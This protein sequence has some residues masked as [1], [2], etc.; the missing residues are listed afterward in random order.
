VQGRS[1]TE[2]DDA[3]LGVLDG[4]DTAH[5][6]GP[7][8]GVGGPARPGGGTAPPEAGSARWWAQ[9]AAAESRRRPRPGGLSCE[10]II[11]AAL[12]LLRDDGLD[13]LTLRSVAVRL[14]TTIASLYRHIASR[15]ELIALIG[16]HVMGDIRFD[17]TGRGWRADVEALM[18][19]MHRIS[20]DQ[21]LPPSTRSRAGYGPNMLRVVDAALSLF[22]EAGLTEEQAGYATITM[23]E[24]LAS[25]AIR[26]A[27]RGQSPTGAAGSDGF[28]QLL[29]ALPAGQFAA[30]RA[31][32]DI[33][34]SAPAGE[35]FD[36]SLAIF[37]DGVASQ[38]P[39][40]SQH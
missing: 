14:D 22:L 33:Y 15:D 25:S 16:D 28:D 39:G 12:A 35:I 5:E 27:H 19:G 13:A 2:G 11:E 32:G 6:R 18:R 31:A 23:L 38:L 3:R 24:F 29:D 34:V 9:R 20:L 36:H 37:L 30:L 8:P 21:P 1:L 4:S 17:R 40:P 7:G 10:R 26:R